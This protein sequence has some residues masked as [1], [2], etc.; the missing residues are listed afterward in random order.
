M[1]EAP[2]HR[3]RDT[4]LLRALESI[5]PVQFSG[6]PWRI[7]RDGRD[8]L[9]PGSAG[10]RWNTATFPVLYTSTEK[11]G[12]LSEMRYH[13][14]RGQSIP[15]SKLVLRLF[16]LH[17]E[18]DHAL[19]LPDLAAL[20]S[21][22]VDAG[23]YGAAS[24]ARRDAEYTRPQQIAEAAR[25]LEFGALLAPSARADCLNA[26]LFVDGPAAPFLDVK[27]DH[28]IVNVMKVVVR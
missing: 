25:F 2:A 10:G 23:R 22:G 13:L 7:V 15:P 3:I 21:L 8:P 4:A 11:H 9:E 6:T 5:G 14:T 28:G 26:I 17:A 19:Q 18:V 12:A 27:R 24:Y 20:S 16:A 1:A